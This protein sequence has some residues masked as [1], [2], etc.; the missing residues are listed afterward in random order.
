MYVVDP[1]KRRYRVVDRAAMDALGARMA[2]MRKQMEKELANMPA[3]Q[4]AQMQRMM[5]GM[6]LA[7]PSAAP[8]VYK[9]KDSGRTDKAA[10]RSCRVYET[11]INGTPDDEL[12]VVP[13]ASLPGGGEFQA[14]TEAMADLMSSLEQQ[15]SPGGKRG[16]STWFGEVAKIKGVPVRI[17]SFD[18]RRK[19]DSETLLTT[20]RTESI[21]ALKF[22]VP[23][24]YKLVSMDAPD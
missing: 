16:S 9:I 2:Q 14:V 13:A 7:G 4:R 18:A 11:A 22:E 6:G 20:W 5:P 8:A 1:G 24:G 15:L 21:P 19:P 12:C 17:R 3:A 10:G 23:K